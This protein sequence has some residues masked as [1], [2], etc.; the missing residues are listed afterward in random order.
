MLWP[1]CLEMTLSF[2]STETTAKI[3]EPDSPKP[4]D[5]HENSAFLIV[6]Y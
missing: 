4:F 2:E 5:H 6:I 1:T 3:M